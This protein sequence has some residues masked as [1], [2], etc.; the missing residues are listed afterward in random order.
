[1]ILELHLFYYNLISIEFYVSISVRQTFWQIHN[2]WILTHATFYITRGKRN[3]IGWKYNRSI[4][5]ADTSNYDWSKSHSNAI[6]GDNQTFVEL[7]HE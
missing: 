7:S 3:L 6:F 2:K 4:T 5:H 1:M